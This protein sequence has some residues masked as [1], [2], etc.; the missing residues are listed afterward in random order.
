PVLVRTGSRLSQIRFR[1]GRAE[2]SIDEIHALQAAE[3]LV[4][5]ETAV[6]GPGGIAVSI[7]LVGEAWGGLLGYR[8]KRHSSVID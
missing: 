6:V 7:D 3:R 1:R 4:D 5:T 2:L 8:A